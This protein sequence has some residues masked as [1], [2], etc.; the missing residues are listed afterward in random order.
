[1]PQAKTFRIRVACTSGDGQEHEHELEIE[2]TPGPFNARS[3]GTCEMQYSC[4]RSREARKAIF[5][6]PP[7]YSRPYRIVSVA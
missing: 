2:S 4:P 7:G 6:C 1:M 5:E 3:E